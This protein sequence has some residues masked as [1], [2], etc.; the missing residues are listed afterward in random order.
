MFTGEVQQALLDGRAD[1]AVHSAKDL[2]STT[3]R[4]LTLVR[5]RNAP[6]HATRWSARRSTR[7]PPAD[8]SATGSVRRRAQLAAARPDLTFSTV[9]RQHRDPA[10]Q[11]ARR[12]PRRDR[13]RV[14]RRSSGSACEELAGEILT[15]SVLLPQAAQGALGGRV[16][17]RRRRHASPPRGDRR[18]DRASRRSRPSAAF[19]AELGGGCTL[20]CGAL[21]RVDDERGELELDALLAALDGSIVLRTV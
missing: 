13:R 10:A 12:R 21:A 3:P 11:A 16:P 17:R 18:S 8:G 4:G 1:V 6:T 19:L 15:P 20:P 5:F 9:A 7:S 14:R 2:P